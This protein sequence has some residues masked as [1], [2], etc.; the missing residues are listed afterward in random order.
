MRVIT[1]TA[2][3]RVIK[4]LEGKDVRPTTDRIKEAVFSI[5]QF[6]V[7]GGVFADVFAGSG[8]MGIEALSRGASKVFFNDKS[9]AAQNI[10][11]QNLI[12]TGLSENSSVVS[13][14]AETFLA[15]IKEDFDIAYIDPPYEEGI[16]PKI[17]P[18]VA[19]KMKDDGI[20]LCEHKLNEELPEQV[21]NFYLA[22]KY[23]YGKIVISTYLK[24]ENL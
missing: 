16:I 23:K 10:I 17:L 12:D 9:T 20:V 15:S 24:K 21:G 3:G 7:P 14:D 22:K 4:T 8:Q 18:I 13:M 5:I 1:G 19:K 2:R 11:K 6:R